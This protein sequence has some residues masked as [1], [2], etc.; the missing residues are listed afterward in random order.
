[1]AAGA[2]AL[3]LSSKAAG[4]MAIGGGL[5]SG[6]M[7][8]KANKADIKARGNAVRRNIESEASAV[9]FSQFQNETQ[10]NQVN[11]V[12]GNQLSMSGL[13]ALERE[14]TLKAASAETGG[15]TDGEVIQTAFVQENMRN[16]QYVRD[17]RVKRDSLKMNMVAD[18]LNFKRG[19]EA[20]IYQMQSPTSAGLQRYT[21]TLQGFQG[22]MRLFTDTSKLLGYGI[23]G[24]ES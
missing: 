11:E 20:A 12:L 7:T 14:A 3:G 16:A 18:A 1:M 19:S 22:G 6:A 13:E 2:A 4:A 21:K 15:T 17:A 5:L 10:L 9:R 24:A 23:K 8:D